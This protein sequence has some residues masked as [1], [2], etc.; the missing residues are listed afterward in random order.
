MTKRLIAALGVLV[1]AA[2]C[3]TKNKA[4]DQKFFDEVGA[5]SKEQIMARGDKLAAK[6]RWEEARK[7]Y[8]FLSDS[9]PNDPL[10]RR[11]SLK[12]ADTFYARKDTESLTEAQLRYKD[13]SNRFPNDPNRPYALLMLGKCSYQQ[14]KGPLRDLGPVRDAEQS[15]RQVLELFPASP[16]AAEAKT[17]LAEA[18][19]DLA[20]HEFE[21]G[22][23]YARIGAWAGAKQRL[24]YLVS[25]YPNTKA[26]R[27]GGQ[28]LLEVE[29]RSGGAAPAKKNPSHAE[30]A[31]APQ[32]H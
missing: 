19:E 21:I 26:A 13:F 17:L 16:F 12:V 11:A 31:A 2:G 1:V 28:L 9:F 27:E 10:G 23:F 14:T 24:E 4:S 22:R 32:N 30:Q 8:S 20:R 6:K 25:T 5:L 18:Q 29:R 7:Y 15:F 3:S